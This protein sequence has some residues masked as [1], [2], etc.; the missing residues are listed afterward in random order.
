M[1]DLEH[2]LGFL[3]RSDRVHTESV[4]GADRDVRHV[5]RGNVSAPAGGYI[6]ESGVRPQRPNGTAGLRQF[7][8]MLRSPVSLSETV[9]R[10][11]ITGGEIAQDGDAAVVSDP[12]GNRLMLAVVDPA[13]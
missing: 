8:L 9:S 7:T 5:G 13:N 11:A 6:W 4:H 10:V 2:V 1:T 3:A 12:S